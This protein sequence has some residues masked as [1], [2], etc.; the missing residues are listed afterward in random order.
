MLILSALCLSA[1]TTTPETP[2]ANNAAG[3][4]PTEQVVKQSQVCAREPIT[5]SH[6]S[7]CGPPSN[8]ESISRDDLQRIQTRTNNMPMEPGQTRG[9]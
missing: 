2:A 4:A 5:G 1:C 6:L 8:V 9:R 3:A 7:R